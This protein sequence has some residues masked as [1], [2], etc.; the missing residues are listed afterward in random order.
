M[1]S[2]SYCGLA[3]FLLFASCTSNDK[4]DTQSQDSSAAKSNQSATR[5]E[6]QPKPNVADAENIIYG[7]PV[8][9]P[10]PELDTLP[11]PENPFR[12]VLKSREAFLVDS[13][14][15]ATQQ[16]TNTD[17]S[18]EEVSGSP[19]GRYVACMKIVDYV[20]SPGEYEPGEKV[21]KEAIHHLLVMS[22]PSGTI[23][24]E[25]PPPE[26]MFIL[27]DRWISNSRVLF[28]TADGFAVG[29][30]FVYDAFRDSLQKVPYGYGHE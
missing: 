6:S 17:G 20:D 5:V 18:I 28:E 3:T 25:I 22:L 21:P 23:I 16:L 27:S 7:R 1:K 10:L 2:F 19:N 13:T 26:D 8:R 4:R 12:V 15:G 14:S 9:Q 11:S 29:G 30:F 24:R